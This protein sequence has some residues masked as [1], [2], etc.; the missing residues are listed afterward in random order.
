MTNFIQ[1]AVDSHGNKFDYSLVEYVN[2]ANGGRSGAECQ[3]EQI[4]ATDGTTRV[5]DRSLIRPFELDIYIPE[6]KIAIEYNGLYWHSQR[7]GKDK[8]YHLNKTELCEDKGVQLIHIFEDEWIKQPKI[9]RSRLRNLTGRVSRKI[10]ARKCIVKEIDNKVKGKFL[11]RYHIQGND[12][13]S[14]KSGLFY[15]NRLVAVMTF[16]K[17]RY[18][19]TTQWELIRYCTIGNFR[20]LGGAGK[21]L[22][23]FEREHSPTSL[24][25]YA[26]R[27]WSQGKVYKA[28]GFNHSHNSN[29]NYFYIDGVLKRSS[30]VKYQK[31]K[32]EK[33]LGEFDP[34]LTEYQNMLTNGIDR[35]W[36]CGNMVFTKTY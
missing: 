25:S 22:K 5:S 8:K 29:P 7:R 9:V 35:I 34:N 15:K 27:R 18:S 16:G 2:S 30:R 21:L 19:K 14:V 6:K 1:K 11:D 10:Y 31:H 24:V 26:D 23:H 36:D 3:I 32:L 4:V 13:S 12:R 28:L 33:L 17:S 20:I